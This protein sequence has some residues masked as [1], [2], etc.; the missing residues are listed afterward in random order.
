MALYLTVGA[1]PSMPHPLLTVLADYLP[2]LVLAA[3]PGS[4]PPSDYDEEHSRTRHS[5][6]GS[7]NKTVLVS[8]V[9]DPRCNSASLASAQLR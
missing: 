4:L 8:Q 3:D 5:D 1:L 6:E 2:V 7:G 9:L